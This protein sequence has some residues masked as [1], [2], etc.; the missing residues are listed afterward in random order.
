MLLEFQGK[1]GGLGCVPGSAPGSV[2]ITNARVVFCSLH[3]A[4]WHHPP[5]QVGVNLAVAGS[6]EGDEILVCV[7]HLVAVDVMNVKVARVPVAALALEAVAVPDRK[8][9]LLPI[10][11]VWKVGA[12]VNVGGALF[13]PEGVVALDISVPTVLPPVPCGPIAAPTLAVRGRRVR[14]VLDR[15]ASLAVGMGLFL[16]PHRHALPSQVVLDAVVRNA[17]GSGNSGD[18]HPRSVRKRC[19]VEAND[20]RP[21]CVGQLT[22]IAALASI[23]L[24]TQGHTPWVMPPEIAV[25]RGRFAYPHYFTRCGVQ[26]GSF[27]VAGDGCASRRDETSSH[28]KARPHVCRL[29]PKSVSP[30]PYSRTG[31]AGPCSADRS[32]RGRSAD[33]PQQN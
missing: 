19:G 17:E 14:V 4:F 2:R 21:I 15:T 5:P 28:R 13:T 20:L 10:F 33:C 16:R 32:G 12:T 27:M 26:C 30:C 23:V 29:A 7:I 25:S 9:D 24:R 8:G 6:T 18:A 3:P 11:G 1:R 31:C 22:V